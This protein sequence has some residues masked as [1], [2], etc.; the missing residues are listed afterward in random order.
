MPAKPNAPQGERLQKVLARAGIASR[1]KCEAYIL[2]G[3]V[4]VNGTIVR[5][6]GTRVRPDQDRIE[7]DGKPIASRGRHLYYLLYKPVGYLSTVSDPEGRP[8]ATSLIPSQK[9]LFPVG[10]LD[11]YSEGLL[12]CTNDGELTQRLTH[13]R[14]EHEKEYLVLVQGRLTGSALDVLRRGITLEDE[15]TPAHAQVTRMRPGWSWRGASTP[16]GCHWIRVVLREG[17]KRQIRRMLRD[18][19]Y[20]VS[21]LVRVRMGNLRLGDLSAGQ[22]RWLS[23]QES[24]ALRRSAGLDR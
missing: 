1:R 20:S 6:L 2:A 23:R 22:G 7:V 12:L 10:R 3:R 15:D 14:F 4:K 19:G 18:L 13:P 5:E 21:R 16:R 9:R 11:L 8:V 17:R 24:R